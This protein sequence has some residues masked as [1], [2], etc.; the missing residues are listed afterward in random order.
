MPSDER[1]AVSGSDGFEPTL[2][3]HRISWIFVAAHH[4]KQ[5]VFALVAAA[6][7]G[8]NRDAGL[9]WPLWVVVP[10]VAAAVWHQWVFRY[11]F[12]DRGLVIHEGLFFRTVRTVDY[13]RIENVDTQR[14]VLHRLLGVAEVRVETSSGGKPEALIRVLSVADVARMRER[15]FER[16]DAGRAATGDG[17]SQ[18]AAEHETLLE[19]PP[20]ELVRYGLI[21]NRGMLVVAAVVGVLVQSGYF[22]DMQ[23]R[24]PPPWLGALPWESLA[25]LG[26]ARPVALALLVLVA[27]IVTTRVLSVLVALVTLYGFRLT[28]TG[29]D[30]HTRFGLLT[31]MSLTLRRRRIQAA[32]QTATLLHRLFERVSLRV[33]LAGGAGPAGGQE[34]PGQRTHRELWLAPLCAPDDAARLISAAL[35]QVRLDGLEWRALAPRARR[36]IFRMMT[37]IWLVVAPLPA[38]SVLDGWW[39]LAVVLG[40]LPLFFVH[41]T[42]YT[43]HTGW[44]LD[45]DFFALR[46][47]W[48]TRKLSVTPRNRIQSVRLTESPFDRRHDMASIEVDHAG[49]AAVSHRLVL[50]YLPRDDAERLAEALYRSNVGDEPLAARERFEAPGSSSS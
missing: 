17:D 46:R 14:T 22:G 1:P 18:A 50:R 27:L 13:E 41:A 9:W 6:L 21:D 15:I 16:R 25:E 19:L 37:G 47:G 45:D 34:S 31:R 44:A 11:G 10:L 32:H 48:L 5:F 28:R 39:A 24:G 35:P 40:P 42:L 23:E 49:A 36:R 20:I 30:L 4:I 38:V 12:S 7:V 3:L 43:R 29:E 2:K 26:A 33:D 8:S